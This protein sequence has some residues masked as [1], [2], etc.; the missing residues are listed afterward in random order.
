MVDLNI[1]TILLRKFSHPGQRS[2]NHL[3]DGRDFNARISTENR[4]WF[5]PLIIGD[6]LNGAKNQRGQHGAIF[7][8]AE[9]NQPWSAIFQVELYKGIFDLSI[10]HSFNG[11][12][13]LKR[14][15]AASHRDSF[16]VRL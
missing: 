8:T 4:D 14:R 2:I 16:C 10:S 5:F 15:G 3:D 11:P 12:F 13:Y 6:G 9:S 7:T 1:E